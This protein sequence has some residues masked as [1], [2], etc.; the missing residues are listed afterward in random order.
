[1]RGSLSTDRL[2]ATVRNVSVRASAG[3]LNSECN[4]SNRLLI[5]TSETSTRTVPASIW[6]ISSKAF[7][8]PVIEPS[9]SSRRTISL[10]ALSSC[11]VLASSP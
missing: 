11:A 2:L 1:M 9:V 5:E 4:R 3:K 10:L 8:M 7:S 6:L